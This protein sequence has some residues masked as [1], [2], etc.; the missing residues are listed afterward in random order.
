M[1]RPGS[2]SVRLPLIGL[3][4]VG[5]LVGVAF[6]YFDNRPREAAPL[7]PPP[8]AAPTRVVAAPT[9]PP[10]VVPI[11]DA[12]PSPDAA[13]FI[14]SA[15]VQTP[16]ITTFIRDGTWD[17]SKLGTKAGY[18]QGTPWVTEPGNVV[19][20]GH[21]EMSDGQVGIFTY[22][23]A[24]NVGDMV[25]IN[26]GGAEY[27]YRVREMKYVAPDDLTVLYPTGTDTL[28]LITCSDYDFISDVY[29]QRLV[30]VSERMG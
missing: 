11:T 9:I 13:L 29:E 22:L 19:L 10:T 23:D 4:L 27:R 8:T 1:Y 28:T 16:I 25:I 26:E 20:S 7:L 30:V 21:V 14:P 12:L 18:L 2:S 3:L 17:V 15:G 24:L 5:V 6:F